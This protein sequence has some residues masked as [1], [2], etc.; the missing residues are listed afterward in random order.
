MFLISSE[1]PSRFYHFSIGT[2]KS[3]ADRVITVNGV[4]KGFA[5]TG[6]RVGFIGASKEIAKACTKLQ[7]QVTSAT[8]AVAQKAAEKAMELEK[9]DLK[10]MLDIYLRR[11]N[12]FLNELKEIKGLSLNTPNGAFYVFPD[13]TSFFG[14]KTGTGEMIMNADDLSMYLLNDANVATVSGA[15]FGNPDNIRLS[16][17][18]SDEILI[19]A[20]KRMKES[21]NKLV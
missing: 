3:I 10:E 4:S 9:P 17:A 20:A 21:L 15:A 5:M 7:G 13:V 6:W 11:R 1:F 12:L 18:T 14:R 16:Y 2:I 19:E 8:C